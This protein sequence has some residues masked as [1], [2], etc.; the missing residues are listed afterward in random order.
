MDHSA[1]LDIAGIVGQYVQLAPEGNTHFL[2]RCPFCGAADSLILSKDTQYWHCLSCGLN[3]DK[4]DFV[5]KSEKMSRAE[6]ILSVGHH[7][8][9]GEPFPHALFKPAKP[10]AAPG[11]A[12]AKPAAAGPGAAPKPPQAPQPAQAPQ[13]PKAAP[14]PPPRPATAA[15]VGSAPPRLVEAF[16]E[17]RNIIG[18]YQGAALLDG[19]TRMIASDTASSASGD[20]ATAGGLL[21]PVL[22]DAAILCSKWGMGSGLPATVILASEDLAILVHKFGPADNARLLAVRLGNPGDAGVA[23]RLVSGASAKLT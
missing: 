23:R 12:P 1:F 5:A 16:Q 13:P 20:L 18:S 6:A 14:A 7:A 10:G 2:G 4:Y 11:A 19:K 3:G 21:A 9:A 22:A 17:F 8:V 15:P